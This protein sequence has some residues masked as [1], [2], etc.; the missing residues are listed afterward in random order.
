MIGDLRDQ[1]EPADAW[2]PPAD[3]AKI[4]RR[5]GE[6]G[7]RT[8]ANFA[9]SGEG[10]CEDRAPTDRQ[11]EVNGNGRCDEV[12]SA[13]LSGKNDRACGDRGFQRV[14]SCQQ[15]VRRRG[16][17]TNN[18]S[19]ETRDHTVASHCIAFGAYTRDEPGPSHEATEA[20]HFA[21]GV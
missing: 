3:H 6:T 7:G 14:L 5:D 13:L 10:A 8:C 4:E 11:Q 20:G 2:E 12:A 17:T 9:P 1:R 21:E 16:R 15:R 18:R 19:D